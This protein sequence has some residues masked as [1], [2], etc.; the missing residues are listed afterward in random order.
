MWTIDSA[1]TYLPDTHIIIKGMQYPCQVTGR[2]NSVATIT[3]RIVGAWIR[4][5]V[6]WSAVV[7]SLNGQGALVY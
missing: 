7:R 4:C 1:K 5:E 6:S 3:L 2:A